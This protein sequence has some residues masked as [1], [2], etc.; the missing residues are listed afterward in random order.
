MDI[1]VTIRI[2]KESITELAETFRKVFACSAEEKQKVESVPTMTSTPNTASMPVST[3]TQQ[4]V[5]K[6][7]SEQ[8][9]QQTQLPVQ[10]MTG[11]NTAVPVQKV[12]TTA[13]AQEYT[14]DQ[15]AVALTGLIDSGRRET[16]TQILGLFGV[17][18][19][20]QIP[21][22]RYPELVLKLREV[23]ANI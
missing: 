8:I 19:L 12:P 20:T 21:K 23:G 4:A 11:A 13:V 17:Q 16:V 1:Q 2:S 6:I 15:V 18:A 9:A 14:Q 22:E 3:S 5:P 7:Y 10:A